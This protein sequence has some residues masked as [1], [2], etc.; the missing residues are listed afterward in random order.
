MLMFR[1]LPFTMTNA[2]VHN[3]IRILFVI[4]FSHGNPSVIISEFVRQ[5]IQKC[6]D[7]PGSCHNNQFFDS[8]ISQISPSWFTFATNLTTV[9]PAPGWQ[10]AM[11]YKVVLITQRS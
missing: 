1:S 10:G 7:I 4:P 11:Y 5:S 6:T 2:F 9:S 8:D 3:V